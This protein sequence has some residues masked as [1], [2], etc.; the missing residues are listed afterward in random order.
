MY[1][2]EY[3]LTNPFETEE[4]FPFPNQDKKNLV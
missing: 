4:Y 2:F 3:V 1:I